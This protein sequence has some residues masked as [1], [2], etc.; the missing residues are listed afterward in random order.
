MLCRSAAYPHAV[1]EIEI[2]ETHISWIILT[3][4]FAYKIKK[5]VKFEFLDFS[6]LD[7]RR[8]Y[9]EEE[10]R[11]NRRLAPELYFGVVPISGTPEDPRVAGSGPAFEYAVR[12][13]QFDEEGLFSRLLSED[14]LRP[15]H[16]AALGTGLAS[17]HDAAPR[18]EPGSHFGSPEEIWRAAAANFDVLGQGHECS[19]VSSLRVWMAEAFQSLKAEF[20]VRRQ[21]GWVRECHGDLHLGNIVLVND[22]VRLFD[23]IEFN[24]NYRWIDVLSDVAFVVMDLHAQQRRDLAFLFLNRYQEQ[25]G[26]YAALNALRWYLVYRA[27]VR[28]KVTA[29]RGSQLDVQSNEREEADATLRD[30]VKLAQDYTLPQQS[31]LAITFGVSGTGKSTAT[32]SL[33]SE[34]G[35]IRIRSDVERKRLFGMRNETRSKLE[36]DRGIYDFA[37][38]ERVYKHLLE[39]AEAIL[40]G[41]FPVIV[42]ATFL[43]HRQRIL[44][45]QLAERVGV[46]FFILPFRERTEILKKRI[47][48]RAQR[49]DEPSEATVEVLEK[50]L[51]IVEDLTS[52]EEHCI[53]T[54]DGLRQLAIDRVHATLEK[55]E[56]KR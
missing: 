21:S 13:R 28:A 36:I 22:Q 2:R 19:E 25:T 47:R 52:A 44:F 35:A 5:S 29:L 26:D 10:L 23:C 45:R 38:R 43:S 6:T 8:H 20:E 24:E 7:L 14:R 56:V 9:C 16:L 27:L 32:E 49:G 37:V 34:L 46:P 11:L 40:N 18:V 1:K 39:L 55:K 51:A 53:R 30:Y 4:D 12:M 15:H 31:W 48:S 17:V 33:M 54:V 42:D 50:Q 41:G 3:G